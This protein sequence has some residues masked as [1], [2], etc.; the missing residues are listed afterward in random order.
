MKWRI[1]Y[2]KS[3]WEDLKILDTKTARKII[4]KIKYFSVQENLF[5]FAKKLNP[6]LENLYRFRIGDYRAI[7]EIKSKKEINLLLILRIKH[8]GDIYR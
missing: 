8:R 3:A 6:P 5:H 2:S 7:F 1:Q 4:L